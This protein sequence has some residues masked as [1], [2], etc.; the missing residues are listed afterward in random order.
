MTTYSWAAD[1]YGPRAVIVIRLPANCTGFVVVDD[2]SLGSAIGGV[3]MAS[4]VTPAEVARLA[5]AMTLKNAAAGLPHG[6]AK[7]G[8]RIPDD[9]DPADRERVIRAFARA[10]RGLDEYIP[11]PDMGTDETAMAWVHDEIGR[12]VGLP[13]LLGGI[14]LD[15]LGATGFGVAVCADTLHS[16]GRLKLAGARVAVQGFGAVGRPAARLLSERGAVV[17]AI[18]DSS[19]AVYDPDGLDVLALQRFNIGQMLCE[20]TD[21]KV[22]D[23]DDL[24]TI[25]CDILVPAAQP[26]AIHEGNAEQIR[27]SAI[28]PGANIAVTDSAEATLRARGVLCVPDFIANAGGVI[29]AAVEWRGGGRNEAFATIEERIR[30]NT[31][32]MLDRMT[33]TG[34]S[35]RNAAE[36]MARARLD[37]AAT[38]RRR[39]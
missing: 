14:P 22:L 20:Y 19:G 28:V 10:I 11:G 35:P 9:F 38:Y 15:E 36:A 3:R 24:L 4:S 29:C 16:V 25:D 7:S 13:A 5:R 17:V 12:A 27:A 21:A 31:V 33:D 1:E 26:D 2:V 18:S 34:A 39:F 32:E 6:G 23:R 8:I 37:R 30:T